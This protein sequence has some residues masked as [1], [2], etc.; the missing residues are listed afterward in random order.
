MELPP[1]L[2][3][4][5]RAL[6]GYIRYSVKVNVMVAMKRDIKARAEFQVIKPYNLNQFP[7]LLVIYTLIQKHHHPK[8]NNICRHPWN[9]YPST[10]FDRA[11]CNAARRRTN[12][13]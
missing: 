7:A 3:T 1:T 10:C 13:L 6:Y 2:P 5:V 4:A 11:G 12:S 9:N 8:S